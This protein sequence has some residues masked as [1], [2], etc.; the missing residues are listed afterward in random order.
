MDEGGSND[1]GFSSREAPQ[2]GAPQLQCSFPD[3]SAVGEK[4]GGIY[5]LSILHLTCDPTHVQ[6]I[7]IGLV[8]YSRD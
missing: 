1:I 4:Q 3:G 6:Y 5:N 2:Q 8:A 7:H